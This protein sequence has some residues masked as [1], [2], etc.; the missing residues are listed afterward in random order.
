MMICNFDEKKEFRYYFREL[1]KDVMVGKILIY[2]DES[3]GVIKVKVI[4]G[5]KLF[6]FYCDVV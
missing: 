2:I 4:E 5:V 6:K 1:K 3:D